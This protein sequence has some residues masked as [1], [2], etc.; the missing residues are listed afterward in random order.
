MMLQTNAP[1]RG[2]V[3]RGPAVASPV[4]YAK[5]PARA[6]DRPDGSPAW[7]ELVAHQFQEPGV[8]VFT[9]D[10]TPDV[11]GR[12]WPAHLATLRGDTRAA[13][14]VVAVAGFLNG[15]RTLAYQVAL[16]EVRV[17]HLQCL[18]NAQLLE[19]GMTYRKRTGNVP[20][21]ATAVRPRRIGN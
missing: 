14:A 9:C 2:Q 21:C 20:A 15:G 18:R 17:G 4:A 8:F 7:V 5:F 19:V 12:L 3:G 1:W 13:F 11:R 10:N 6:A 16:E